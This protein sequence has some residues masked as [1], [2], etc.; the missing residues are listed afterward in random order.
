VE[1]S[2][3]P[4]E[5]DGKP[6]TPSNSAWIREDEEHARDTARRWNELA[7]GDK[8]WVVIR[9]TITESDWVEA[10]PPK[11]SPLDTFIVPRR[12]LNDIWTCAEMGRNNDW[13][14]EVTKLVDRIL[15]NEPHA[16]GGR[17][18]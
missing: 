15:A 18:G 3:A 17:R 10:D 5:E 6:K 1:W 11:D 8:T 14:R 7:M 13:A 2:V 4:L 16:R 9:R 12:V